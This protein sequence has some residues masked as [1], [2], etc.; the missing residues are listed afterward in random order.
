MLDGHYIHLLSNHFPIILTITGFFIL[1]FGLLKHSKSIKQIGLAVLLSASIATIPAYITGEDAEEKVENAMS[2][3]KSMIEE[4]EESAEFAFIF[5]D[6]LGVLSLL[7]LLLLSKDSKYSVIS[8]RITWLVGLVTIITLFKVGQT[9]GQI[10]RP[11]L[12][13]NAI[14]DT[15]NINYNKDSEN[16]ND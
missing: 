15:T 16:D 6:I 7:S 9:G 3:S 4:H 11:E 12:R 2:T 10:R 5:T 14:S 1:T 13:S 8:N